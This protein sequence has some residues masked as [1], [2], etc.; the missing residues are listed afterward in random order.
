MIADNQGYHDLGLP[1]R[2][3]G[4]LHQEWCLGSFGGSPWNLK[5]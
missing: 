1:L 2:R 4:G 5:L 3:K